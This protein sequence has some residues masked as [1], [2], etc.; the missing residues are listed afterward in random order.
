[1]KENTKQTKEQA[2][3][4]E[5]SQYFERVKARNELCSHLPLKTLS[6]WAFSKSN[7]DGER[8]QEPLCHTRVCA[9]GKSGRKMR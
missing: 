4:S 2:L 3:Q 6:F 5:L 7:A 8:R 1:M 9:V